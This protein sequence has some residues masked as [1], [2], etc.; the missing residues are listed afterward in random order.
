MPSLSVFLVIYIYT[1]YTPYGNIVYI[2]LF[3]LLIF[4]K[5]KCF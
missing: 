4:F 2:Q 3:Y 5:K 1:I